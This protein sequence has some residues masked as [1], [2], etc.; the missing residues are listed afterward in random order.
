M[1]YLTLDADRLVRD[2]VDAFLEGRLRP[3]PLP[4]TL[5]ATKNSRYRVIAGMV[6]EASDTS[7]MGAELVGWLVEEGTSPRIEPKW[8][9][10]ARAI[11][12]ERATK[13]VVVTSK[14]VARSPVTAPSVAS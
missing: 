11:F 2:A 1:S 12:A 3:D 7:L 14:V 8:E 9:F 4:D 10:R 5:Y 13:H 6:H